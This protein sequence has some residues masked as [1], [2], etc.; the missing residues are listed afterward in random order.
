[1]IAGEENLGDGPPAVDRRARFVQAEPIIHIVA[2]RDAP[3]AIPD[4]ERHTASQFEAW[5]MIAGVRNPELGGSPEF[6]DVL[7]VNYYWNNQWIHEGSHTPMGHLEHRA[8][9]SMLYELWQRYQRPI[10]ITE[11]GAEA[12][13][14]I[15]WLGY[16]GAEVR[17]ARRMG[18][19]ILGV[20]LYPVMD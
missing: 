12:V 13:S 2:D 18:A 8:L 9:H 11:T 10:I 1:M 15:G 6:L 4:A 17:Q 19:V 14:A 16:V 7:G 3:E 5:D 20:C